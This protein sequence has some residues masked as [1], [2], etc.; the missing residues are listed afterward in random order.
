MAT[1][2]RLKSGRWQAQVRKHG[3][4]AR[5]KSFSARDDAHRWARETELAMEQG[6]FNLKTS[7]GGMH[8]PRNSGRLRVL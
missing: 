7:I 1:L 3:F 8:F 6:A 5:T 4:P 2:R